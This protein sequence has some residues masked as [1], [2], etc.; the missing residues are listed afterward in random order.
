MGLRS[1]VD[2]L[3]SDGGRLVLY[4]T[5]QPCHHSGGHSRRSMGQHSTSCTELLIRHVR[6]TLR[7][8]AVHLELRIAYLYRAHWEKGSFDPKYAPAV[9][10]ARRGL[11]LLAKEGVQLS[12][13][14]PVDWQWLVTLCDD[15]TRRAWQERSPPF[16]DDVLAAR[17]R[18]DAFVKA[19]IEKHAAEPEAEDAEAEGELSSGLPPSVDEQPTALAQAEA[20]LARLELSSTTPRPREPPRGSPTGNAP[21]E[22][23]GE[24]CVECPDVSEN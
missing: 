4:M 23:N 1:A 12:A 3:G 20:Q 14:T 22:Q 24:Q 19:A 6:E 10:A 5:Y 15:R 13:F 8:R 9:D 7:S 11:Q 21:S 16:R 2:S 18:M 17:E